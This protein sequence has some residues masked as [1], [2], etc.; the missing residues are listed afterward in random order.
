MPLYEYICECGNEAGLFVPVNDRDGQP[1]PECGEI[2]KRKLSIP[3]RA[4][5]KMTAGEAENDKLTKFN[6]A[7]SPRT[8]A[9]NLARQN[10]V[11]REMAGAG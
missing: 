7:L 9:D 8:Y 3:Q 5:I 2:M 11:K 10:A 4:I 6:N 1:C